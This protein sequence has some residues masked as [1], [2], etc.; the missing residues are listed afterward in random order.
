MTSSSNP[1]FASALQTIAGCVSDEEYMVVLCTLRLK[2]GIPRGHNWMEDIATACSTL[3][4]VY[5]ARE[6]TPN[7]TVGE[8]LGKVIVIVNCEGDPTTLVPE[9]TSKCVFVNAPL[10]LKVAD[11]PK[12]GK[13]NSGFVYDEKGVSTGIS[14]LNTQGQVTSS[15]SMSPYITMFR[16]FA[17]RLTTDYSGWIIDY[18][19]SGQSDTYDTGSR[20]KNASILLQA[21][22]DAFGKS[23]YAHD[24]WYYFGL[25][26]YIKEWGEQT[27]PQSAYTLVADKL[28]NWINNQVVGMSTERAFYPVGIV[29]M[30]F[31]SVD[32]YGETDV[33]GKT[34]AINIL[35]LNN[36]YHKAFDPSKPAFPV[37]PKVDES[38]IEENKTSSRAAAEGW[39]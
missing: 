1:T 17:P 24:K 6:L 34:T 28:N 35:K 37:K 14:F 22:K 7:T 27:P 15:D 19:T 8:V 39:D 33:N 16:G 31:A 25:G 4:E 38:K 9:G 21:S 36:R 11:F 18:S 32:T 3:E 10:I 12:S 23:G 29:L 20:Q 26:G 30:N 13:Y 5:D 2:A